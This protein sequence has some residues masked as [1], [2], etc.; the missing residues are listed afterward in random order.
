LFALSDDE[1]HLRATICGALIMVAN[2]TSFEL[3][4]KARFREICAILSFFTLSLV[5]LMRN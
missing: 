3:F 4:I 1:Q 2:R 5:K